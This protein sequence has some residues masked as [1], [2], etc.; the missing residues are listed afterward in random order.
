[1][2]KTIQNVIAYLHENNLKLATAESCTGGWVAKVMT[3]VAGSS[4]FFDRGF[5]TYSN[6]SKQEMLGVLEKTLERYGAV[7]EQVVAEMVQG[8]LKYSKAELAIAVSGI[9]GPSGGSQEKPVGTVCFSWMQL[10]KK[11]ITETVLFEGDRNNIRENSVKYV[12]NGIIEKT[13]EKI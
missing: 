10:G 4:A 7:S 3:D 13:G 6:E 2:E 8:T 1:M 12:L 9:A 11:P 5:V